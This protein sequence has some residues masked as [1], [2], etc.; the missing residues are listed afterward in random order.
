MNFRM[1]FL[2]LAWVMA[3]SSATLF[4]DFGRQDGSKFNEELNEVDFDA[5]RDFIN[6]KRAVNVEEKAQ[7]LTISGDVRT[8]WRHLNEQGRRTPLGKNDNLRGSNWGAR[9]FDD[10]P[11]SRNDWDIE[12]N[13][14]FEYKTERTWAVMQLQFDNAAGVFDNGTACACNG[15]LSNGDE[16]ASA[17]ALGECRADPQGWHGSHTC[18]SICLKKAYFGYN[19]IDNCGTKFDVELGRRRLNNV[20]DSKVQFLSPFDGILLKYSSKV[21]YADKVY[22]YAGGFVVNQIINQL[23]WAVET[24]VMNINESGFDL[25]YSFIDWQKHGRGECYFAT[26]PHVRNPRGFDFLIS[27]WTAYYHLNKEWCFGKDATLYGAFLINHARKSLKY[28]FKLNPV[29]EDDDEFEIRRSGRANLAWYVGFKMGEVVKEG[30]WSIE[31]QYQY[32]QAIAVPDGDVRGIGRG[33]VLNWSFTN[34]FMGNTNFKG[35]KFEG[36]Y[37]LTDNI[38]LDTIVEWSTAIDKNIGGNHHYSCFKLEAIY[39]F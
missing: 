17:L 23:A 7:N 6:T 24:G 11:I 35:W 36:L 8:E 21:D 12:A 13:L 39:A 38:T 9:D 26:S 29:E 28:P 15:N 5:L 18:S 25:K 20:F 22:V 4:A 31:V 2:P 3:F 32:V 27:Q 16:V 1:F 37:A 33:N 10:L 19:L 34:S 30:D 14:I